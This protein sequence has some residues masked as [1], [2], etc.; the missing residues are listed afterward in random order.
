MFLKAFFAITTVFIRYSLLVSQLKRRRI[1]LRRPS[2]YRQSLRNLFFV[3]AFRAAQAAFPNTVA[4]FR[5]FVKQ[6]LEKFTDKKVWAE[7]S[8]SLYF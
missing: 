8:F 6:V 5:G 7:L 3:F 2:V 1:L 4:D